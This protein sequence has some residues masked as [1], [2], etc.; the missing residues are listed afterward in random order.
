MV[1]VSVVLDLP[2]V[3]LPFLPLNQVLLVASYGSTEGLVDLGSSRVSS[4]PATS[5][6]PDE[7]QRFRG[8]CFR[9]PT[10]DSCRIRGDPV[11]LP[12]VPSL[13]V[14]RIQRGGLGRRGTPGS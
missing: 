8:T 3:D 6:G 9:Y 10:H 1:G 13:S 12:K 7:G 2:V 4:H 5:V 11:L 14:L